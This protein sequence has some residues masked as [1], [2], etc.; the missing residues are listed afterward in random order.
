M[1]TREQSPITTVGVV[2]KAAPARPV[3]VPGPAHMPVPVRRGRRLRA[4]IGFAVVCALMAG[5]EGAWWPH[6]GAS[7]CGLPAWVRVG[8]R[9]MGVGSCA[10]S[11]LLPAR[12]V[13]L[14]VGQTIDV[15][16]AQELGGTSGSTL[17]PV[18]PLP[19][20]G[21]SA[22]LKRVAVSADKATATYQGDRP[23]RLTLVSPGRCIL[24]HEK[25]R[26]CPIVEVTVTAQS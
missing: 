26:D 19:Q 16:M 18:S 10:G 13:T 20:V 2:G 17:V 7:S 6:S 8:G 5:C 11:F 23:G 12:K 1:R 22:V 4:T 15:H 21:G 25:A 24:D 3:L 14:T 9:V